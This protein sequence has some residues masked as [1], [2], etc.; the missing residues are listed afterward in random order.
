MALVELSVVEQ[1]YRAVLQV[2]A[3]VPVTAAGGLLF[4]RDHDGWG[5]WWLLTQPLLI[6][7]VGVVVFNRLENLAGH[8]GTLAR[9]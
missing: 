2:E 7:A 3:G 5:L 8:R 4:V 6:T 1:R 9:R